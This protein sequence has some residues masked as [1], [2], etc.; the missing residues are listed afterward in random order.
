MTAL[1]C[2]SVNG[3]SGM[4]FHVCLPL[5]NNCQSF[6]TKVRKSLF[7]EVAGVKTAKKFSG[8]FVGIRGGC[9]GAF[10]CN[11]LIVIGLNC[12]SFSSLQRR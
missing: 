11:F 8:D 5:A 1:G 9:N 12:L 2:D 10:I 4:N 7:S 3:V 6:V